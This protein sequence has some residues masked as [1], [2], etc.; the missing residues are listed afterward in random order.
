MRG[1][2]GRTFRPKTQ[3]D[4]NRDGRKTDDILDRKITRMPKIPAAASGGV[5]GIAEVSS[6]GGVSFPAGVNQMDYAGVTYG[7]PYDPYSGTPGASTIAVSSWLTV[8]GYQL[9]LTPGWYIP[10]VTMKA[11]WDDVND[12]PPGFAGPYM[13]GGYDS[14]HNDLGCHARVQFGTD[15]SG[16]FQQVANYGPTYMVDGTDL[17]AELRA[18]GGTPAA[19][20]NASA[21]LSR[22]VWNI[23]KLG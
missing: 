1:P 14:A 18:L 22:V 23:T 6:T 13:N 19:D 5:V 17:H 20:N 8:E 9:S 21:A 15:G 4:V 10:V 2:D 12:A 16:G 3:A 11:V 7:D